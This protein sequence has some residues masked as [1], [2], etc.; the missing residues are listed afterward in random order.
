MFD[1]NN[2]LLDQVIFGIAH[3]YLCLAGIR[4]IAQDR[5]LVT[6]LLVRHFKKFG[7]L[8]LPPSK[9]ARLRQEAHEQVVRAELAAQRSPG[10]MV[11]PVW[12]VFMEKRWKKMIANEFAGKIFRSPNLLTV[13]VDP[14]PAVVVGVVEMLVVA[15]DVVDLLE[16]FERVLLPEWLG[17]VRR[18]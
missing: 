10:H 17:K 9:L 18:T 5:D 6:L 1:D 11:Y 13:V 2:L 8:V 12:Y 16:G 4:D 3:P 14:F 7:G 15:E